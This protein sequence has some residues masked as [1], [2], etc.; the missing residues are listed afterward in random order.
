MVYR[1]PKCGSTK[2]IGRF[3]APGVPK[4]EMPKSVPCDK[5]K[6]GGECK[7]QFD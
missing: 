1:C 5:A 6:C 3:A 7:M 2:V 4:K